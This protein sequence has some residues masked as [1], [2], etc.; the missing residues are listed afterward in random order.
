MDLDEQENSHFVLLAAMKCMGTE[1]YLSFYG[2]NV[3]YGLHLI[4]QILLTSQQRESVCK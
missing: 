3:L 1:F 2:Y 4:I